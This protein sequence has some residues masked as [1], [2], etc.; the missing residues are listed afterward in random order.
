VVALEH[1]RAQPLAFGN[2]FPHA[3]NDT[4]SVARAAYRGDPAVEVR[5]H[6]PQYGFVRLVRTGRLIYAAWKAKRDADID[7]G[8]DDRFAR[9]LHCFGAQRFGVRS[10]ALENVGNP[11]VSIAAPDSITLP[12]PMTIRASRIS[13]VRRPGPVQD[14]RLVQLSRPGV[15]RKS[16]KRR[17]T[18]TTWA[19]LSPDFFP[20][21]RNS[22]MK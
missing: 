17:S 16:Q 2:E 3:I 1:L 8:W 10:F 6:G 18:T 22:F 13:S 14:L 15:R 19:C 7:Q 20:Y 5:S 21:Y 11:A 4:A 12:L 9:G